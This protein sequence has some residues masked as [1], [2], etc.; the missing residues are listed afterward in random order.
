MNNSHLTKG[1]LSRMI[2]SRLIVF[3]L[4]FMAIFF[5]TAGTFL[6]WEAWA[7][8][9]TLIAPMLLVT[10]Y[11]L[12][13]DPGLLE[14]RM[15][16]RE[17]IVEQKLIIMLSYIPFLFAYILPGF[18]KRFGWSNVPAVVVIIA[19][20]SV[21]IGY[22]IIFLV[23]QENSYTS[24]IIEVEQGQTVIQ[25]GPYAVVRHPMYIGAIFLYFFSPL[26]LGSGWAMIPVIFFIPILVAR[27]LNEEKVL[28]RDLK[29]YKE[30]MQ[31]VRY[32]LIPGIW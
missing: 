27:I 21:L 25:S 16:M 8:L 9:A 13:N 26:A 2:I 3:V 17:K 30:Y 28:A 18:D 11:L 7:Y 14:R 29:G 32:R 6:Y 31:K 12:K 1:E 24:R 20:C 4:L 10:A 22:G 19:D 23:F 5:L 15:R